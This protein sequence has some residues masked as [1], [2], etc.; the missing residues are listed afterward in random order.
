MGEQSVADALAQADATLAGNAVGLGALGPSRRHP[1]ER[2]HSRLNTTS[3]KRRSMTPVRDFADDAS[4]GESS[5]D[6]SSPNEDGEESIT[7]S[8]LESGDGSSSAESSSVSSTQSSD[9]DSLDDEGD[10]ESIPHSVHSR[11]TEQKS[12][13]S[14]KSR[15]SHRSCRS[16]VSSHGQRPDG[17]GQILALE[18]AVPDERGGESPASQTQSPH[19]VRKSFSG[20]QHPPDDRAASVDMD[21]VESALR[22]IKSMEKI[23]ASASVA[24][25]SPP[26]Q[27]PTPAKVSA[28]PKPARMS[29]V[30][31][32]PPKSAKI[33]GGMPGK[34]RP[35]PPPPPPRKGSKN[36]GKATGNANVKEDDA[37]NRDTSMA[38]LNPHPEPELVEDLPL[39]EYTPQ[40]NETIPQGSY[41]QQD[42][43]PRD[44]FF[45]EL[46]AQQNDPQV[47]KS[48]EWG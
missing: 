48:K 9:H 41:P 31:P 42:M 16:H 6:S 24:D 21:R 28:A 5:A 36:I 22:R 39:V 44:Q 46:E 32:P 25:H 29:G 23:Q 38:V 19:S 43:L 1:L 27:Q 35:P 18:I 12:V 10:A 26:S 4:S 15:R 47:D 8:F 20:E 30:K 33:G 3:S 37:T 40:H 17:G 7:P 2:Q 14:H 45:P 11:R 34:K 13:M